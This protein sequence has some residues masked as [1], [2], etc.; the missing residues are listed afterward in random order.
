MQRDLCA[1]LED[2]I[3]SHNKI[4]HFTDNL[5]FEQFE[6]SDLILDAVCHNLEVVGEALNQASRQ[7]P[8]AVGS[9][10]AFKYAIAQRNR[11]AHGYFNIDPAVL[12]KT[13]LDDLPSLRID[14][15]RLQAQHCSA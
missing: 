2:V 11:I 9:V 6:A 5:T 4:L 7:F 12:W 13:V 1:Y 14:V 3:L 8:E 15:E 10:A